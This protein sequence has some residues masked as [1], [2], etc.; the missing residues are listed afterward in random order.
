MDEIALAIKI[1]RQPG[2]DNI[3]DLMKIKMKLRGDLFVFGGCFRSDFSASQADSNSNIHHQLVGFTYVVSYIC[4][5]HDFINMS[6][7]KFG[8]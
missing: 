4:C 2:C 6:Y 1:H 3:S 8:V 5:I 7:F